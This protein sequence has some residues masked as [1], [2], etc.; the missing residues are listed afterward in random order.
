M[1]IPVEIYITTFSQVYLTTLLI[2]WSYNLL[3]SQKKM[4]EYLHIIII[5]NNLTENLSKTCKDSYWYR[6]NT[7]YGYVLNHMT[8]LVKYNI[9]NLT[10]YYSHFNKLTDIHSFMLYIYN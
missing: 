3:V 8:N 4:T 5:E 1:I 9:H 6:E 10:L 7:L 2:F